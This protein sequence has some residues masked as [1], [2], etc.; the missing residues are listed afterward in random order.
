MQ[1]LYDRNKQTSAGGYILPC[2]GR[3]EKAMAGM[4]VMVRM[5]ILDIEIIVNM[6]IDTICN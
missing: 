1:L 6:F 5:I 4:C 3:R 2:S